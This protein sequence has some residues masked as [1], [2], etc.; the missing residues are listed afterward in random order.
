MDIRIGELLQMQRCT[1]VSS[2]AQVGKM[3]N[4]VLTSVPVLKLSELF[5]DIRSIELTASWV[6][7]RGA[8]TEPVHYHTSHLVACLVQGMGWL[9]TDQ[10]REVVVIGDVVVIPRGIN[11]FFDPDPAVGLDYIAYE[12]SDSPIDYQKHYNQGGLV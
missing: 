6:K 9:R 12:I 7:I 11:H 3:G 4:S 5:A 8:S 1:V 10:G 2:A